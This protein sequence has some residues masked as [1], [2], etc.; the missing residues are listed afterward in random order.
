[1]IVTLY[2]IEPNAT[3]SGTQNNEKKHMMGLAESPREAQ[4]V[5]GSKCHFYPCHTV[6]SRK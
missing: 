4:A 1:M 5:A 3:Q 2:Y 6:G